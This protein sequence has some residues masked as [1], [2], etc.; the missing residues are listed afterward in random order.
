MIKRIAI[1]SL[2]LVYLSTTAGFALSLHFCGTKISN[3]RIN[4]SAKKPCCKKEAEEKP[5]KC[6]KDK[7]VRIKV[8]DLQQTA[9]SAKIPAICNLDLY[10]N[11]N[12]ISVFTTG[13]FV[14][15]SAVSY[16]GPPVRSS[17]PLTLQN[18][19]FRI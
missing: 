7:H 5:D 4:Q 14:S 17:I 12:N 11:P 16:R 13:L 2:L 9:Q 6:C 10:I 1:F 3:I 18:C 8:S 15:I 19:I